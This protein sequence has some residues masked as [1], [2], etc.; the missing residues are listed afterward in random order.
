MPEGLRMALGVASMGYFP[1]AGVAGPIPE[2]E[3]AKVEGD[4]YSLNV[5]VSQY[6]MEQAREYVATQTAAKYVV[7]K[8]P[9]ENIM[10][11]ISP[12]FVSPIA[13]IMSNYDWFFDS[14]ITP[15]RLDRADL[16]AKDVWTEQTMPLEKMFSAAIN[17]V[18]PVDINPMETGFLWRA[19]TGGLGSSLLS[20]G[21]QLLTA[22][23]AQPSRPSVPKDITDVFPAKPFWSREPWGSSSKPVREMYDEWDRVK[24][25]LNSME[26]NKKAGDYDRTVDIMREH[27]EFMAGQILKKGVEELSVFHNARRSILANTN[28][29]DEHRADLLMMVDQNITKYAH[30]MMMAYYKVKRDPAITAQL[31]ANLP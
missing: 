13:K 20:S 3:R 2:D 5:P 1:T 27:P 8:S 19:Y 29:T 4:P 7:P 24:R 9:N 14:P 16:L 25:V 17:T 18:S 12:Q 23:G 6:M 15:P 26:H 21:D 22:I 31:F 10:G 28:I 30:E 11:R